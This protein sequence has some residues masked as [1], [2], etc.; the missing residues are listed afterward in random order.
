MAPRTPNAVHALAWRRAAA[1]ALLL[2]AL[3][4]RGAAAAAV[5][6]PDHVLIL[7]TQGYANTDFLQRVLTNYS[8]PTTIARFE[9]AGAPNP[10]FTELMWSADGSPKFAGVIM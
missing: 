10:N 7:S 4:A 2:P 5:A 3:L 9:R 1:A 8:V 6:P